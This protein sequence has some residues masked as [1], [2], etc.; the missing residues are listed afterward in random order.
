MHTQSSCGDRS[1]PYYRSSESLS[2]SMWIFMS[3]ILL[4]VIMVSFQATFIQS[5]FSLHIN[6]IRN[7]TTY[8][9]TKFFI[10]ELESLRFYCT[11]K[12]QCLNYRDSVLLAVID[13]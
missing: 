5:P 3:S 4:C 2:P 10:S 6:F 8:E 13:V 7:N 11:Y 9:D 1:T 12:Y